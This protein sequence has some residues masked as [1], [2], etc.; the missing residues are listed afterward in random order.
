MFCRT[1]THVSSVRFGET[2]VR[3]RKVWRCVAR[4]LNEC[5]TDKYV[6]C[7]EL[8]RGEFWRAMHMWDEEKRVF[9]DGAECAACKPPTVVA[10]KW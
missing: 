2:R 4:E 3:M 5:M 1:S 7:K 6:E 8:A 10:N 9:H